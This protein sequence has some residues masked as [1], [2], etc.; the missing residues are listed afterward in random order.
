MANK[1]SGTRQRPGFRAEPSQRPS[2]PDKPR[3]PVAIAA[4][5]RAGGAGPHR[6]SES[7]ERQRLKVDIKKKLTGGGDK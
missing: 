4:Q 5:Q 7:A 6:K 3:N 1:T 2:K